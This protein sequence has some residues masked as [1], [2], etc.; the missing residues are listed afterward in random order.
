MEQDLLELQPIK[1]KEVSP[2]VSP[3]LAEPSEKTKATYQF[4]G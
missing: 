2:T 3:S 4:T 1:L